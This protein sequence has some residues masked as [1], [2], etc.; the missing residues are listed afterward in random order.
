MANLYSQASATNTSE[1][2]PFK[3]KVFL[4]LWVATLISNIGTWM[5]NVTAG[6]IMTE[7]SPSPLMVSLVQVATAL[8]VFLFALPAGALGDLFN[9]RKLLVITQTLTASILFIFAAML[10]S[11]HISAW[12]LLLFTFLTGT[13]SAFA[14]PAWQAI[15][16]KLVPKEALQPAIALNGVSVNV[17]RAIGPAIGGFILVAVGATTAVLLGAVSYL[18]VAGALMWW[19]ANTQQTDSLPREHMIGAMQAGLRFASLS[20]ELRNTI[21]GAVGFCT[22]ASAY[23]A[24]LPLIAKDLFHGG[25]KLYGLLLASL[26]VGAVSGTFF[27]SNIKKYLNSNMLVVIGTI[28]S[29]LAMVL[30][31]YGG[32]EIVGLI[33][34]FIAGVSWILV[35]SSLNI[36]AQLALPDWVRARGLAIY[37]MMF[38]VA[39][40]VGSLIWGKFAA[41]FGISNS[42]T[43][44]AISSLAFIPFTWRFKLNLGEHHDYIPSGHWPEPIL[45]SA[46]E[47]DHGPVLITIDY[48]ID[49]VDQK[50]YRKLM[51]QLGTLRR[52]DGAIVWGF[53]EDV[54]VKGHFIEI[55]IEESWVA[56]MRQHLRV[57]GT[58]K[59]LQDQILVLHR[60]LTSPRVTHAV[61]TRYEEHTT[62]LQESNHY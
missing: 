5:F 27:I 35:I 32:N 29:A 14:S 21:V 38:Y 34:G 54:A 42:L 33:A 17:A 56:H 61:M 4:V 41:D 15:V 1:L 19:H 2:A 39:M 6:W 50:A 55:F 3:Y 7:I 59:A 25:P 49:V 10:W 9:K 23:W 11:E 8:P 16:P 51:Y 37:Q 47:N 43:I 40:T 22:F 20:Q 31:A 46:I 62:Y 60:G 58:H 52:R 53:Y 30:F 24:L 45:A 36:S 18:V 44:A 28:V 26:G 57:S 48:Q 12:T 13:G